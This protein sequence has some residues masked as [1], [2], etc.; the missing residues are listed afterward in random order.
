MGRANQRLNQEEMDKYPIWVRAVWV[1]ARNESLDFDHHKYLI[2]IYE[3]QHPN[4]CYQKAAQMGLSE[5]LISEAVW[6]CDRLSKNVLY[7]FPTS[8]QLNDFVQ[9]RLEPVFNF[10]E[11]LSRITGVLSAQE[12]RDQNLDQD[13]KIAK[14]GLKQIGKAF[15]YLR[16]SQNEQQI[17]TVD[18]DMVVLDERDRF[19]QEHVPYIDKRLLHS[20]LKWRREASTPTYPGKGINETY[21]NSDQRVWML[22]CHVCDLEQELD[23]FQNIDFEKKMAVCRSCKIPIDRFKKGRWVALSPQNTEVHG[24]KISGIY[25]PNRKIAELIDLFEKAKIR[26]FSAMQQFFN[27][28]LGLPYEAEGQTI[29]LSDLN[30]CIGT[31]EVAVKSTSVRECFAGADVGEKIHVVISQKNGQKFQYDWIGTVKD[32][33]GPLD[34]LEALMRSFQIKLLVVDAKPET[35]KVQELM[36]IF[37]GKV[38]A[39]YYPTRNFDVQNYYVYDDNTFEVHLDRTISIDYLVSDIQN[40]QIILPRGAEYIPEFYNQMMSSVR[41]KDENP[42][43]GQIV[44]RWVDRDQPDHY[45]HAANY[46]RIAVIRGATGQ[47]LLDSYKVEKKDGTT[48][49]TLYGWL[50][51][52]RL[53]GERIF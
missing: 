19:K 16:G 11:Y 34:S 49:S 39:A 53:K 41:V 44:A 3:D 25:N 18:A 36:K 13:R 4:I 31:H 48:P 40:R 43:T 50:R 33:I 12:K 9:A 5:R 17:I 15:M 6:V 10:S 27:Q 2:E 14:V 46:N 7:T 23:F 38:Y 1:N 8:S 29:N 30:D 51:W 24:Y 21:A 52:V 22:I 35:R 47:A 32:F 42:K 45:L 37:P 28:V 20:T 26:G